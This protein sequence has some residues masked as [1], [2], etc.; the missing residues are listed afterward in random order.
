MTRLSQSEAA[1]EKRWDQAINRILNSGLMY[2]YMKD[3][4]KYVDGEINFPEF[5]R[6]MS[7]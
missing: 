5:D 6:R 1:F 2:P 7:P 3:F 4:W